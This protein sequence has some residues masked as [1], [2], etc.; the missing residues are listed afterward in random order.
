MKDFKEISWDLTTDAVKENVPA[1]S[2]NINKIMIKDWFVREDIDISKIPLGDFDQIG[3]Y[4]ARKQRT[5]DSELYNS[6]GA[7]FRPNYER[8]M[9]IY[10]LIIQNKLESYL[11][12]GYGRGYSCF[13][14]AMAFMRLG[15]GKVTTVD[16]ALEESQ[17]STLSNVFPNDLFNHINFVKSTSDEFFSQNSE[18]FDFIYIDGDHTYEG[19]KKDW[20]N[21]KDLYNKFLLFDDYHLPGKVQKDIDVSNL[22]DTIDDPT[23]ELIIMDRRIFFDDRRIP[24]NEI[25]Y[26]QVLL[27]K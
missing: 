20:E 22:V 27:R 13:C 21:S 16:P 5:A 2:G 17:I 19:V 1:R 10:S 3:N 9:L 7:F 8:G 12:I 24:D 6:A 25:N 26:G 23:K 18:N 14:A 15:K 4:T 11:E